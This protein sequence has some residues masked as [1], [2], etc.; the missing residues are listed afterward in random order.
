MKEALMNP[1]SA[2]RT[3]R[4]YMLLSLMVT[5]TITLIM[6]AAAAPSIHFES[7]REREEEMLFRGQQVANAIYRYY[8]ARGGQFPASFPT[9]LE[10]L[11]QVVEI[12]GKRYRFLRPSALCDPMTPCAPGGA[13]SNWKP[14]YPGDPL[15]GEL[16]TAYLSY[17]AAK[18]L[19]PN[20]SVSFLAWLAGPQAQVAMAGGGDGPG[21]ENTGESLLSKAM[22]SSALK[23]EGGPIVGVVS[24]SQGRWIRNYYGIETYD[25]ALFVVGVAPPGQLLVPVANVSGGTTAR[26]ED[27]SKAKECIDRGGIWVVNVCMGGGQCPPWDPKCRQ[28]ER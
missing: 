23:V 25:H 12:N 14:V 3:Q 7:Q 5:M 19:P 4:G 15:I 1:L 21:L 26:P 6:L 24:R 11:T 20:P 13:K 9:H 2:R 17:M 28:P 27:A 8:Q 10:D 22:Q 18:Q 16:Y